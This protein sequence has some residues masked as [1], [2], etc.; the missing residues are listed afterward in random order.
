MP[1]RMLLVPV[2]AMPLLADDLGEEFA[3]LPQYRASMQR[4]L[5]RVA[6]RD[7]SVYPAPLGDTENLLRVRHA[8]PHK[9]AD[10]GAHYV[11]EGGEHAQKGMQV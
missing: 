2:L 8:V 4:T 1:S 10:A 6:K 7:R 9:P 5:L 3:T 11:R